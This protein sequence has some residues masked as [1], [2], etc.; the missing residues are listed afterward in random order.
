M[1]L[2]VGFLS[3]QILSALF[4][5]VASH[6][7]TMAAGLGVQSPFLWLSDSEESEKVKVRRRE[8]LSAEGDPF[9]LLNTFHEWKAQNSSE[10]ARRRSGGTG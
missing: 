10:E 4:P 3:P 5:D 9:T 6:V 1:L 2:A 7:V 8:L